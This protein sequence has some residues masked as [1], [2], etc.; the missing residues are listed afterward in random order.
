MV[1]VADA[2]I[3]ASRMDGT[4]LVSRSGFIPRHLCLQA[5]NSLESVNAKIIG[6]VLNG[7]Q[8]EHQP[9][10]YHQYVREY[11]RYSDDTNGSESDPSDALP[12]LSTAVEKL[13]VLKEPSLLFLTSAWNRLGELLKWETPKK[14]SKS[15]VGGR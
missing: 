8:S 10:Y 2:A 3:I 15:P 13:K 5:K 1:S 7:V 12:Q 4:I 6:C 11:G 14:E 9:Y